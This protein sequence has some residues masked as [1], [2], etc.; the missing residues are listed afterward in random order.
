ML[1]EAGLDSNDSLCPP[2]R[3]GGGAA[4]NLMQKRGTSQEHISIGLLLHFSLVAGL[5]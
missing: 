1:E 5:P 4:L 3:F 2:N